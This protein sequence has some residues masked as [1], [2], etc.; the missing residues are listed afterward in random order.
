VPRNI[1]QQ[2]FLEQ[3][4][5]DY[6][7]FGLL[8]R[9]NICHR[10]HYLQMSTE[11]LAKVYFWRHGRF[12]GFGHH[13]FAPFLRD[14][15]SSRT[16]DFHRMFSYKD[17]RRFDSQKTAILDLATRI[18]ELAPA[19]GNN[20]PNPEY[21]WP[22]NLPTT[23]PLV[24]PFTEWH[25]WSDSATGRRLRYFVENLLQNYPTLFP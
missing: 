11:K 22:P 12:P 5:S 23:S 4:R 17:P 6:E 19:H 16:A 20:G 8:S 1:P 24:H 7:V 3:A 25:D 15:E 2:L 13:R 9:R 18:Q 21:P 14:L 10:L